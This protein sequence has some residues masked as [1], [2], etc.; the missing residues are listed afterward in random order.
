MISPYFLTETTAM[1]QANLLLIS[2]HLMQTTMA[3]PGKLTLM[4]E[5]ADNTVGLA[6]IVCIHASLFN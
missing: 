5:L 1:I 6:R 2:F 3:T 4:F